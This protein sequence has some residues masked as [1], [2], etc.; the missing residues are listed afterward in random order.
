[1]GARL[2]VVVL[3]APMPLTPCPFVVMLHG[4]T[5]S[6]EDFAT[7]TQVNTL[8]QAQDVIVAYPEPDRTAKANRC[9]N[10]FRPQDQQRG[11]GEPASLADLTKAVVADHNADPGRVLWCRSFSG[12]DLQEWQ[13]MRWPW[14]AAPGKWGRRATTPLI[15]GSFRGARRTPLAVRCSLRAGAAQASICRQPGTAVTFARSSA[16]L[17]QPDWRMRDVK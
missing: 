12:G 13:A 6:A 15:A 16:S 2:C 4:C 9:W 3:P 7:G 17:R 8:A 1:M 5:Q 14:F 10:G 11:A